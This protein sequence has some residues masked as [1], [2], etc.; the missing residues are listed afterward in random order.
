MKE[1]LCGN[2][3]YFRKD[4]GACHSGICIYTDPE[5]MTWDGKR[6]QWCKGYKDKKENGTENRK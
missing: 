3:D 2:C 1:K 6:E 4:E 5:H